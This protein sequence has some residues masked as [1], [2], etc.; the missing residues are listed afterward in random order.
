MAASLAQT[1]E[2]SEDFRCDSCVALPVRSFNSSVIAAVLV[3]SAIAHRGMAAS[4][5]SDGLVRHSQEVVNNFK[6]CSW[7]RGG[8]NRAI[9]RKFFPVM[10]AQCRAI[11]T[12][13]FGPIR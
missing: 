12:L 3:M 7:N 10:K 2:P 8:R 5:T 1:F 13:S 6:I 9:T 4:G 11:K